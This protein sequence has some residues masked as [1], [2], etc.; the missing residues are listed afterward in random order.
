M[1][2]RLEKC[3]EAVKKASRSLNLQGL[4]PYDG[5]LRRLGGAPAGPLCD[6]RTLARPGQAGETDVSQRFRH[7]SG[8]TRP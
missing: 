3:F 5:L 8:K 7:E 1:G 6:L 2:K 4:S